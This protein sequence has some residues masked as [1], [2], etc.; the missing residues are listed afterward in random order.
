MDF[1]SVQPV[2]CFYTMCNYNY[3]L[4]WPLVYTGFLVN[5]I[6]QGGHL[7]VR[8]LLGSGMFK[9]RPEMAS[10]SRDFWHGGT[11]WGGIKDNGVY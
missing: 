5:I 3:G 2:M 4:S 8:A 10:E 9:L 11:V 1:R 6:S 7:I